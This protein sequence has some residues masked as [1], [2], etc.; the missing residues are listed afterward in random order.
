MEYKNHTINYYSLLRDL[1]SNI[2]VS[3]ND[4][5]PS[6]INDEYFEV[7]KD[8]NAAVRKGA[9]MISLYIDPSGNTFAQ[10]SNGNYINNRTVITSDYIYPYFDTNNV[11]HDGYFVL[12]F[13]DASTFGNSDQNDSAFWYSISGLYDPP[14]IKQYT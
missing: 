14:I 13:N 5:I 11:L 4:N 10:D 6:L 8:I 1:S 7:I 12:T 9:L 2:D 3:W